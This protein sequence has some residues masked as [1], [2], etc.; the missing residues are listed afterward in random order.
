MIAGILQVRTGS[1]RLPL[2]VLKEIKGKTL[3]ELY[4]ERVIRSKLMDNIIIAT[5]VSDSDDIIENIANKINIDCFRGSE[6]DLVD[7]YYQCSK[8]YGVDVIVRLCNDDPFVDY[9]VIDEA[10]DLLINKKADWVTN[11]LR[12]TYP[13]GLDIDVFSFSLLKEMWENASLKSEREHVFPYVYNNIDRFNVISME[14]EKDYSDLRWTLDYE[15]DFKMVE[16]VYGYLYNDKRIFLQ[17][18]ILELL[19]IH[20]EIKNINSNIEH[21]E[22]IKKSFK[23]EQL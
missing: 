15:E 12:P 7:R 14:Q 10:I 20:P 6:N 18:D 3:I 16:K 23:E 2:K 17:N 8:R 13:E 4:V 21:Y 1:T 19:E 9:E 5:T 22:G 11:H